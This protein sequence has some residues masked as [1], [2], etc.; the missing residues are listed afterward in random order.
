M[1][2]SKAAWRR[3]AALSLALML[4]ACSGSGGGPTDPGGPSGGGTPAPPNEGTGT[5]ENLGQSLALL[6]VSTEST[7]R[8]D[9]QGQPYPDDYAPMGPIVIMRQIDPLESAANAEPTYIVGRPEELFLGG[10]RLNNGRDLLFNVID[11]ISLAGLTEAEARFTV[12]VVLDGRLGLDAP[13]A[14]ET[15]N[16]LPSSLNVPSGTRRDTAA[17]DSNGNGFLDAVT[18]YVVTAADGVEELRLQIIDGNDA[19]ATLDFALLSGGSLLPAY[20]VRVAAADLDGDGRDELVVAIAREPL[21]G[22]FDTPVGIYVVDDA[23]AGFA[24]I[25][26]YL[27]TYEA[28]FAAPYVMLELATMH[29]DHDLADEIVLV[30]N[31]SQRGAPTPGNFATRFLVLELRDGSLEAIT[32]GPIVAEVYTPTGPRQAVAVRASVAAGDL[33]GDGIDELLFGGLEE[34][35]ESCKFQDPDAGID[36]GAQYLLFAYGGRHNGFAPLRGA[37]AE[38]LP[39]DCRFESG[40]Q[41]FIMRHVQLNVLDFD[42]DGEMDIQFNDLVLDGVPVRD[43]SDRLLAYIDDPTL[44]Y[45]PQTRHRY[46]DRSESAIAVSDQTGDGVADLVAIYMDPNDNDPYIKV[47]TWDAGAD[48]GYRIATRIGVVADDMHDKT[49]I[50][51]P[52]DVDNDKV[53]QLRYTGEHFLDITEPLVLAAIAAPP[54]KRD[55]G[56]DSCYSSW[57]RSQS[58]AVGR[59]FSVKVFGHVGAGAGAAGVGGMGKW[60]VKLSASAAV[61][62]SSSYELS[63]SQTFSTGPFEDGVVFTSIPVDRYAYTLIRDN[64]DGLGTVGQRLEIRLP[65]SPDIRI[66]E[67]D[68]Y[69]RSITADAEPIDDRVFGH[70]QGDISTYPDRSQ[71]DV[72]LALNQSIVESYR[73]ERRSAFDYLPAERGLEVG[74]VLVGQGSGAT[75]LALEYTE[76][77]GAA[78]EL[79][80][81]V[82]FEAEMMFGAAIEWEVGL[83]VGRTLSVSHGDTTL[84][85]GSVDSISAQYYAANVYAFGLF[86]Y[87]QRLG[88]QEIEVINF[89][90]EE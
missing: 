55:I 15:G 70:S 88:D 5:P 23:E 28:S 89:W 90:V 22:L 14:V 16:R 80:M 62:T 78:N 34:I 68:Y 72:L 56:Q 9:S 81:G 73:R 57:G 59:E 31:E 43:W 21:A 67:R 82:S 69:N 36:R 11:D 46:F 85:S 79:A 41:P 12:P 37:A 83:E 65:R 53:A 20:D 2:E 52:I 33:D 3:Y 29:A 18:A 63:K 44:I 66:V 25:D 19:T 71:K 10:F 77:V 74:P 75:E 26:E 47:Y 24:V 58:G 60:V 35:V 7:D 38:V 1:L 64:T 42:G 39:P 6:G 45:G 61:T 87:L 76:T 30:I 32:G 40:D 54:C 4:S 27:V 51:V 86:A 13:W 8:I 17:M 49:P 50:I 84:F 48:N